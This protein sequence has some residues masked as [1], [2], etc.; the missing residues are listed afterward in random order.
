MRHIADEMNKDE[1]PVSH[2]LAAKS[3]PSA[4]SVKTRMSGFSN[5]FNISDIA[6]LFKNDSR[7]LRKTSK[8]LDEMDYTC[9]V[10]ER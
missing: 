3:G 10:T 7:N 4:S 1:Q 6:A 2:S 5:I 9:R 8:L